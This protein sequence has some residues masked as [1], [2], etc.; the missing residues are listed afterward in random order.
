MIQTLLGLAVAATPAAPQ[1]PGQPA[2]PAPIVVQGQQ[3]PE[4]RVVCGME[5]P[6][7]SLFAKK[8]CRT[9]VQIEHNR[10]E[11][12]KLVEEASRIQTLGT[13]TDK[14]NLPR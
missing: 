9:V 7:G 13:V 5:T 4:K 2:Q 1:S 11:S 10:A 6:T 8:V 3:V 12:A 14:S